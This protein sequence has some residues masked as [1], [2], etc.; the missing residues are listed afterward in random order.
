MALPPS[1]RGARS[2]LGVSAAAVTLPDTPPG[3]RRTRLQDI[4]AER[5]LDGKRMRDRSH[6][7]DAGGYRTLCHCHL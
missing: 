5:G 1:R 2:R 7:R 3:S 4:P 6:H